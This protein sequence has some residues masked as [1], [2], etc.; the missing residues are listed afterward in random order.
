MSLRFIGNQL[1]QTSPSPMLGG[2]SLVSLSMWIRVNPGC[3]VA[4]AGGV[5]FFGDGAGRLSVTLSGTGNLGVSWSLTGGTPT[6]AASGFSTILTAGTSHHL[7]VTWQDGLQRYFIDGQVVLTDTQHG[8]LG[9]QPGASAP[10]RLGSDS[11][12]T[13]LTVDEP[14]VWSGYILTGTD[15][16]NLRDRLVQ[17]NAI[18]PGSMALHWTLAGTAGV[19]ARSGDAGLADGSASGLNLATIV[20]SAPAY[21][22][23]LTYTAAT[24]L[25]SVK[26]APSGGMIVVNAGGNVTG[27][28]PQGDVQVASLLGMPAGGTFHLGFNGQTTSAISVTSHLPDVSATWTFPVTPGT[29][30]YVRVSFRGA[31]GSFSNSALIEVFDG[32]ASS[33]VRLQ[34]A[35]F[36]MTVDQTPFCDY[37]V[38][39]VN[40]PNTGSDFYFRA[41]QKD[42][43]QGLAAVPVTP[44]STSLAIRLTGPATSTL[45]ALSYVMCSPTP[46]SAM[47]TISDGGKSYYTD[48]ADSRSYYQ[49]MSDAT[50]AGTGWGSPPF[51]SWGSGMGNYYTISGGAAAVQSALLGL[52]G[53][54]IP[55]GGVAVS[56]PD[57]GPMTIQ[58]AGS[59]AGKFQPTITSS[60][61]AVQIFHDDTAGSTVGG[62]V[63]SYTP[64]G[65]VAVSLTEVLWSPGLPYLAYPLPTG[66]TIAPSA[67]VTFSAPASFCSTTSGPLAKLDGIPVSNSSGDMT[68]FL[69]VAAGAKSMAVGYNIEGPGAI[70]SGLVYSNVGINATTGVFWGF[71]NCDANGYP[72]NLPLPAMSLYIAGNFPDF[73]GAGKGQDAFPQGRYRILWDGSVTFIIQQL[74]GSTSISVVSSNLTGTTGN[75]IVA[76]IRDSALFSPAFLLRLLTSKALNPDG[77]CT[78]DADGTYP[79]NLQNFRVYPPDPSDPTG[80]TAWANPPKYYPS[81]ATQFGGAACFR[82]MDALV[83]NGSNVVNYGDF[84]TPANI[85]YNNEVRHL[86]VPI[87]RVEGYTGSDPFFTPSGGG[88]TLLTTSAPHGLANG[89]IVTINGIGIVQTASGT[90]DLTS[91]PVGG[92][93]RVLSPTTFVVGLGGPAMTNVLTPSACTATMT[94]ASGG[95][96]FQDCVDLANH[97]ACAL[98]LNVPAVATDDCVSRM[99]DYVIAHRTPGQV[100]HVELSNEVW[101]GG[102]LQQSYFIGM[103]HV[104]LGSPAAYDYLSYQVYR[105]AQV[106]AIFA[107]KFAAAGIPA[108]YLRR[109]I[110]TTPFLNAQGTALILN[111]VTAT[112][113]ITVNG[114]VTTSTVIDLVHGTTTATTNGVVQTIAT[115]PPLGPIV[116]D[117]VATSAYIDNDLFNGNSA[118]KPITDAFSVAQSRDLLGL[119]VASNQIRNG[120]EAHGA[121]IAA[122]AMS[123]KPDL[124]M[125]E[126]NWQSLLP[127]LA[128]ENNQGQIPDQGAKVH[129]AQYHPDMFPLTLGL[130]QQWQD[131]GVKIANIFYLNGGNP[132]A[133]WDTY[134]GYSMQP[135]TGTEAGATNISD[136]TNIPATRSVVGGAVNRWMSMVKSAILKRI[137]PGRSAKPR[138]IGY[139]AW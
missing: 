1:L 76:D 8:N 101:N 114:G 67:T 105:S 17:P 80:N 100:L 95:I 50:V 51:Q 64:S 112:P 118:F 72:R 42:S 85:G 81:L 26:V 19:T 15:V 99:A 6:V 45:I 60:D 119:K 106:H 88:L 86:V 2:A 109:A 90:N 91:Q 89:Q 139:R 62:R 98:W 131:G 22:G 71:P 134:I 53:G 63:P 7:A 75:E 123:P 30:Y 44:S 38:T 36:D 39:T 122:S 77:S 116:F 87:A 55:A 32:P 20:G 47:T 24:T 138:A 58:F 69:Q 126:C 125:Y 13:D 57:S 34:Q 68:G 104:L 78:A 111:T 108:T 4:N 124:V 66:T 23:D 70:S 113:I 3:N 25:A 82:T 93:I 121:A 135:G 127:F 103:S 18:A 96:P 137:I 37:E 29:P 56:G 61:P 136:P 74:V 133:A 41:I 59:M 128:V 84:I 94:V 43:P 16:T 33:G 97:L 49:L 12:G 14:T 11:A 129:A 9:G 46:P 92:V 107:A 31:S 52:G 5:R 130:L 102:F 79:C 110:G 73:G 65:G 120:L 83:T 54:V 27:V 21:I 10:F 132:L 40:F 115:F 48:P 117:E 28:R 35:S